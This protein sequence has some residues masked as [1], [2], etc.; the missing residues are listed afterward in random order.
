[1]FAEAVQEMLVQYHHGAIHLFPAIP[2]AFK[3]EGCAF[4]GLRIDRNITVS[5]SYKNG[6]IECNISNAGKARKI[7][8][9]HNRSYMIDLACGENSIIINV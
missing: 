8:I 5:A 2:D 1:M 7:E 6:K 9:C 3:R 4:S